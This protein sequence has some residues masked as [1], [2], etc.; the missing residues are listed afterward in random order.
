MFSFANSQTCIIALL[1]SSLAAHQQLH[2]HQHSL[3]FQPRFAATLPASTSASAPTT[4]ASLP[5]SASPPIFARRHIAAYAAVAAFAA[6]PLARIAP[7]LAIASQQAWVRRQPPLGQP[8][9]APQQAGASAQVC[10]SLPPRPTPPLLRRTSAMHPPSP[11]LPRITTTSSHQPNHDF[12]S[13]PHPRHSHLFLN[14]DHDF[15]FGR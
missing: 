15:E 13:Q 4:P 7:P 5:A 9:I 3:Q 6:E 2:Q 14:P 12:N 1:R 11:T 8:A 10:A